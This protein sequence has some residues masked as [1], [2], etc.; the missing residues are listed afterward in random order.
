MNLIEALL[1]NVPA[2]S[3]LDRIGR[4]QSM[5]WVIDGADA[6]ETNSIFSSPAHWLVDIFNEALSQDSSKTLKGSLES[7]QKR[8]LQSPF[9]NDIASLMK[10]KQG[11]FTLAI[12]KQVG[13]KVSFGVLGDAHIVLLKADNSVHHFSDMRIQAFSEKTRTKPTVKEKHEQM[14]VNRLSMNTSGGYW[15]GTAGDAWTSEV[16]YADFETES[17][18]SVLLCSDGFWRAFAF[19]LVQGE[20]ILLEKTRLCEAYT[21]LREF[22]SDTALEEIKRHDDVSAQLL[23]ISAM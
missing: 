18:K 21:I 8:V 20:S 14:L 15:A 1:E 4:T 2:G 5:A 9:A 19:G 16:Q 11:C 12:V 23:S 22:E 17:C 10:P 7:A 6:L 13:E 3:Q